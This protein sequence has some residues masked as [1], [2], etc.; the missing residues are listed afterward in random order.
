MVKID[1]LMRIEKILLEINNRYKFN[2]KLGEAVMLQDL[3]REIGRITNFYFLLQEEFFRKHG[4]KE[5]LQEYHNS[6]KEDNIYF[7]VSEAIK[8]INGVYDKLADEEL[9]KIID[10]TKFWNQGISSD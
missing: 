6:L 1:E 10:S 9:K 8:F 2:L 3:L 7:N 4:D 5:K